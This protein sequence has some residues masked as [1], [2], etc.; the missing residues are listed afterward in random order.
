MG[1]KGCVMNRS[2][3]ML[4]YRER[5]RQEALALA[6]KWCGKVHRT[7]AMQAKCQF[8]KGWAV[9]GDGA[10][11]VVCPKGREIRLYGTREGAWDRS[12]L[13]GRDR[14]ERGHQIVVLKKGLHKK[15]VGK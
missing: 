10:W 5:Q 12:H 1:R 15:G 14:C 6:K 2:E 4:A 3:I 11:G 7:W 13:C 9:V 8:G